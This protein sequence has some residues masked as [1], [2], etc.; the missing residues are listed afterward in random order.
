MTIAGRP[1]E[2]WDRADG[3]PVGPTFDVSIPS[4][5]EPGR[6]YRVARDLAGAVWHVPACHAWRFGN[7]DCAHVRRACELAE[8][9]AWTFV[10]DVIAA[11]HA[12]GWKPGEDRERFGAGVFNGAL[13]ATRAR[14]ALEEQAQIRAAGPGDPQEALARHADPTIRPSG[15]AS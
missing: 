10:Q 9:P 11:W 8:D 6:E 12:G 5:S 7:R 3:A 1:E 15:C 2:R 13:A 4:K 14:A